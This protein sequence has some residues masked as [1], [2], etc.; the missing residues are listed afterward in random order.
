MTRPA[1]RCDGLADQPCT[2]LA[3]VLVD[4]RCPAGHVTRRRRC[5]RHDAQLAG[6]ERPCGYR[7][8][9]ALPAAEIAREQA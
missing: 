4:Y 8:S 5:A 2:Q 6:L 3:A 7:H 9:C 1:P